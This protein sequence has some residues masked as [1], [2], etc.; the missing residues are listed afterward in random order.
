MCVGNTMVNQTCL[1]YQYF[2]NFRCQTSNLSKIRSVSKNNENDRVALLSRHS[3]S[4]SDNT[5]SG[6]SDFFY[7]SHITWYFS[8]FHIFYPISLKFAESCH[9]SRQT[10]SRNF[11]EIG[12]FIKIS[13]TNNRFPNG[14]FPIKN[15]TFERRTSHFQWEIYH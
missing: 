11:I 9:C 8:F 2:I 12:A 15:A 13:Y 5:E 4:H 10:L 3:P 14:N 1:I 7:Y 6:V